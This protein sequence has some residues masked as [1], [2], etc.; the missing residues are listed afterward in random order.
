[1]GAKPN[2]DRRLRNN[3]AHTANRPTRPSAEL[4]RDD[5]NNIA[6]RVAALSPRRLALLTS[7]FIV[8]LAALLFT[9]LQDEVSARRVETEL[10]TAKAASD[11]AASMN[12]AMMTGASVRQ[13]LG[14]CH[15]GGASATF[16]LSSRRQILTA[17]GDKSQ[18]FSGDEIGAILPPQSR[19]EIT[20]RLNSDKARLAW[21][22][23]DNGQVLLVAAPA[24]DFYKRTPIWFAYA[25]ILGAISLVMVSLMGAF[26]RQS[27]AAINAAAAIEALHDMKDALKGG[28]SSAWYFN[29]EKRTITLSRSFLEPLGFGARDRFFTLQEITALVHP[30]DLRTAINVFTGE[31]GGEN[32]GAVRLRQPGG[33]WSRIYL[34]A[35]PTTRRHARSGVAFDLAGATTAGAGA[36]IAETRLKDAIETIPE[37]FVLWD[38]QNRLVAWNRRF[39]AIFKLPA[40]AMAAGMSAED[41]A[42]S[43]SG[44]GEMLTQ[45]FSPQST[46]ED[47][48]VEIALKGDQ[49]LHLSRRRTAEGGLVCI[50]NNVTDVKRRARAQKQKERILKNAVEELETARRD[51]SETMRKYELEKHRAEEASRSKSE[52]LANMSHELR[53][54][55]NAING[56]SEIMQSELYG[57]LG[58]KKYKEYVRDILASGQHLLELIDDILDMSKIEAGRIQ[59]EPQ[60]VSLER[61]LAE[62]TRLVAKRAGDAGVRLIESVGQAPAIWADPRAV[63][64]VALNLLSNAIKFT[65]DGGEVTITAEADL[66]CVTIIVADSGCGIERKQLHRLGAPFELPEAH[67]ARARSGSG[68]GLA[69]S[70]SLMELQGGVL[71][72]AS[73][74]NKGTVACATFPRRKNA[75]VTLPKFIRGE[76]HILTARKRAE[77]QT[78][79]QAAE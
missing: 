27:R 75:K 36:A 19:G 22:T 20:L 60:R 47:Q 44:G 11:C 2:I 51:Q 52:F 67:T 9:K 45:Y 68:L 79:R 70:K 24:A 5:A 3:K 53:T 18:Y 63:K 40:N 10:R 8:A 54:P 33:A 76:A 17:Y 64:Q 48:S 58:D 78:T 72:I 21:L 56:F 35:A 29:R 43:I 16:H 23:L 66:D 34:R 25:L 77:A 62:S 31:G 59:L 65:E 55:L 74:P 69:L 30:S 13:T 57:P 41:L 26:V 49:W 28:R 38:A 46:I 15:A 6:A 1:M 39:A 7:F 37:A 71:A 14:R 50:A 42:A 4:D 73:Q 32:E 12:I 61:T